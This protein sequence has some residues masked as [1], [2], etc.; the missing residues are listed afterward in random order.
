MNSLQQREFEILKVFL[1]IAVKLELNYYLVCGSAL[2]AVKYAG[3]IPWDDDIDIALP[4][5]DYEIFISEG[6]KIL[7]DWCFLQ[8]YQSDKFFLKL[9]SKLRDSRT[10]YIEDMCEQLPI[11]HGIFIDIFPLDGYRNNSEQKKFDNALKKFEA[12]RRVNL[13][14]NRFSPTYIFQ[15]QTN[16][17]YVMKNLFGMY[18]DTSKAVFEF[19]R[20]V[21]SFDLEKSNLWCNYANSSSSI[22]YAPKEQ[23]GK[24]T[25]AEFEG[26]K[27]RV[28]EKYDEYLTQKYGS[29]KADLPKEQ[30]I[31]HHYYVICDT[32]KPYTEYLDILPN[33]KVR[34][35]NKV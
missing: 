15:F 1:N 35:K 3:F 31:G 7:P 5:K 6:K 24:G 23:Y 9:G 32:D 21:S 28:P 13:V 14:Y 11:N 30:Q 20:L 2:G 27:V 8:N 22:E 25:W 26:L 16:Y 19:D 12:K 18:A 29:W 4:R 33:G 10:T 34:L 17:Y